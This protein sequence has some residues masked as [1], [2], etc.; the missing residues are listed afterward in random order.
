MEDTVDSV[1]DLELTLIGFDMD[2]RSPALKGPG[3]HLVNDTDDR[4]F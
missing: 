3:D 2:V 1:T 4:H